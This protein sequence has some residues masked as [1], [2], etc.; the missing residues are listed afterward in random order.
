[1]NCPKCNSENVMEGWIMTNYGVHFIVKGTENKFRPDAYKLECKACK[2]CNAIFDLS[3]V[4][5]KKK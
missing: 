2:D 3:I 4:P 5:K 1:M